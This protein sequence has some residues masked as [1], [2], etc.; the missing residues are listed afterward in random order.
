MRIAGESIYARQIVSIAVTP[1]FV[2]RA[3]KAAKGEVAE[4]TL[5]TNS[6]L[7]GVALVWTKPRALCLIPVAAANSRLTTVVPWAP[8][9]K[10]TSTTD[11]YELSERMTHRT[12]KFL[13]DALPPFGL[14]FLT[15]FAENMRRS[16]E[17]PLPPVA[18]QAGATPLGPLRV[19]WFGVIFGVSL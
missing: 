13:T 8:A 16:A 19:R 6:G 15:R 17:R 4:A 11:L 7:P 14:P 1:R 18:G 3:W 2:W 9:G 5:S 10:G 12:P